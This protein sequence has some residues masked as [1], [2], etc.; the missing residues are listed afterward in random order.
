MRLWEIINE[1]KKSPSCS[2][3]FAGAALGELKRGASYVAA[4]NGTLGVD[5]F[6]A[7]GKE[8]SRW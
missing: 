5:T 4:K 1:L 3:P 7:G 6:W 2:V 8:K